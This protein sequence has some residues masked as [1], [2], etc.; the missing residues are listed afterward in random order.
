MGNVEGAE[1]P[2]VIGELTIHDL[3]A[4]D[5]YLYRVLDDSDPDNARVQRIAFKSGQSFRWFETVPEE[6]TYR[7]DV[8]LALKEGILRI[9]PG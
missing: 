1:L 9:V 2:S 4:D 3:F 8:K 5:H 7:A 6:E